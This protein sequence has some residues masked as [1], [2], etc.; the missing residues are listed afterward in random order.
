MIHTRTRFCSVSYL[1][2]LFAQAVSLHRSCMYFKVKSDGGSRL[3][4]SLEKR[5]LFVVQDAVN[6]FMGDDFIRTALRLQLCEHN[7]N[8]YYQ[9]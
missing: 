3:K 1:P 4:K 5:F 6:C 2:I 8:K 9:I 7:V